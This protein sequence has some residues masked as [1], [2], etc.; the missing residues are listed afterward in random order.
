MRASQVDTAR[1]QSD[2]SIALLA[3][4]ASK[5]SRCVD[6]RKLRAAV[7]AKFL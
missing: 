3:V 4:D 6:R 2:V 1:K 5:V 7:E